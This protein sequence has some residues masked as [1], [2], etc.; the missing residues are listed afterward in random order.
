M[1]SFAPLFR[2]DILCGVP[3]GAISA[4]LKK[5]GMDQITVWIHAFDFFHAE[6]MLAKVH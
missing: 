4:P 1:P 5:F 2:W 6:R 3:R